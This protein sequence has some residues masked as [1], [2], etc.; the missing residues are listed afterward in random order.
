[1]KK[2]ND[3]LTKSEK[4]ELEDQAI[5]AL[6]QYGVKFSVPLK[7]KPKNPPRMII[8]WNRMFPKMAR[9]WRDRRIPKDWDVE[10]KEIVDINWSATKEV[11][12]RTFHV[13]PL[14]G[15][16]IMS[17]R[18]RYIEM[19]IED[20]DAP[21]VDVF[22]YWEIMAE[23]A[24]IAIMNDGRIVNSLDKEMKELKQFLLEH[25]ETIRLQKLAGIINGMMNREGFR[26]SI[27][28]IQ[29]VGITQPIPPKADRV[30]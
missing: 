13:K 17:L 7:I 27:R 21:T 15:G 28:S 9:V 10:L 1:M 24:A 25:L 5:Q 18:K 4:L 8:W 26:N 2:S 16:T 29:G 30:E 3:T 22:K 23:I 12:M 14:F 19:D 11:Y 6:L 20:W